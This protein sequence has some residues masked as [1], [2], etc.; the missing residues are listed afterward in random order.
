MQYYYEARFK[1]DEGYYGVVYHWNGDDQVIDVKTGFF[2]TA[3]EAIDDVTDLAD[4][5]CLEP[6]ELA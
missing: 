1:R 4:E 2:K 5:R 6:L 3:E